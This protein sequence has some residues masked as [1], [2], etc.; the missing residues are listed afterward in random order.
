MRVVIIG[1]GVAGLGIGWRL[2]QAGV[3]VTVLERGQPGSGASWAA[4]GMIAAAAE[5]ADSPVDEIAFANNSSALWPDFAAELEQ[6][7]GGD[8]GFRQSGALM[9]DS[10]ASLLAARPA[11]GAPGARLMTPDEARGLVPLLTGGFAGALWV[12]QAQVDN[13][14]LTQ[15]LAAAFQQAGGKL[16]SNEAVIEIG[17]HEGR[18][19]YVRTP[20]GGHEADIIILAA[21]AWSS[22][23]EPDLAPIVPVKG[24]MIALAPPGEAMPPAP[25]IWADGVYAVPRGRLLLL[26]ATV[27]ESGYNTH[28]T[29]HAALRLRSAAETVMPSLRQ[30][31]QVDHWAGLRPRA[32]D[33]LPLLGP[34]ALPGLFLAGGQYRNGILFTPAIARLMADIVLGQAEPIPAFDPRRFQGAAP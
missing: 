10:D 19:T 34:T 31:T 8:I 16:L 30:W 29:H 21:G 15:A 9:L 23:L 27:E 13:R 20:F 5:L 3:E 12:D 4:A 1:G 7:S 6:A 32:P 14:R 25:C 26:G 18:A 2:V 11:N 33:G 22:L 17:R 24:E 28:L